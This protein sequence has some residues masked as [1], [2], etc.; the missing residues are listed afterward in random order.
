MAGGRM[1]GRTLAASLL[2]VTILAAPALAQPK[3][4]IVAPHAEPKVFDPHQTGVN[5]TTMHAASSCH[6]IED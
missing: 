6:A 4:L 2:G 3:T 1:I 5:I